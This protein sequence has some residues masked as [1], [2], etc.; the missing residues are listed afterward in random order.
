VSI[1]PLPPIAPPGRTRPTIDTPRRVLDLAHQPWDTA[2]ARQLV[3]A[4]WRRLAGATRGWSVAE[5]DAA[6]A[7]LREV[8]RAVWAA[9]RARDLAGLRRAIH[10]YTQAAEPVIFAPSRGCR[11]AKVSA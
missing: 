1:P 6:Q 4:L 9:C 5:C 11:R 7:Q 10:R 3:G 8:D 2:V